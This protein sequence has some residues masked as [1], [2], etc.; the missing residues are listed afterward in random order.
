MSVSETPSDMSLPR[1]RAYSGSHIRFESPPKSSSPPS[2]LATK[3]SN[4]MEPVIS[5]SMAVNRA[6]SPIKSPD[7]PSPKRAKVEEER[8]P[9]L[10]GP[11]SLSHQDK[12]EA[13]SLTHHHLEP[14]ATKGIAV[15]EQQLSFNVSSPI[16]GTTAT[17]L[18]RELSSP[19]TFT[20]IR[21][22]LVHAIAT[23]SERLRT[24]YHHL[25]QIDDLMDLA[26]DD[27]PQHDPTAGPFSAP[28]LAEEQ[29]VLQEPL[30]ANLPLPLPVKRE[31]ALSSI[32]LSSTS[33]AMST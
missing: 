17:P 24:F 5:T 26:H 18:S 19:N 11:F 30:F 28:L 21:P 31:R 13:T 23:P 3:P 9:A 29:K 16:R 1:K 22:E 7:L 15:R 10:S 4:L 14:S 20:R 32:S 8:H 2:L 6:H 27:T 25:P 12:M 33:T